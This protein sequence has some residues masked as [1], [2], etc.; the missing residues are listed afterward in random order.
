MKIVMSFMFSCIRWGGYKI[1]KCIGG[2]V[3]TVY[4][5]LNG[6]EYGKH[7]DI[8]GWC[9][10]YRRR[11]SRIQI[12]D[13]C[14]FNSLAYYNHIGL[15]HKC[16]LSTLL[17]GAEISIGSNCGMS[18]STIN[19]FESIVIG[20]DVRIGANCVIMDGDFHLDDPR[21]RQPSPIVIKDN[22]W[23]GA[24]VVVMKGV[25]IGK[26]SIIGMNSVVTKNIPDNVVAAG[27]PCK[28]IREIDVKI[29]EQ[30]CNDKQ[31]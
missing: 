6:V 26:N 28:V 27:N 7:L 5:Y 25:T 11:N 30:L 18:A 15:N 2:I 3:G 1:I 9:H 10:V 16:S 21:S 31:S 20:N 24:N 17:E 8:R 14:R 29:I 12:G 22:V 4:M 19:A 13:S 23:L